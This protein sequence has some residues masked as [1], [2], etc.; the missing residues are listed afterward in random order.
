M[1]NLSPIPSRRLL[2]PLTAPR[3]DDRSGRYQ[4]L[5]AIASP[6]LR[7]REIFV[8]EARLERRRV[9]GNVVVDVGETDADVGADAS[10][11]ASRPYVRQEVLFGGHGQGTE[12]TR[13]RT[14]THV[15]ALSLSLSLS[16]SLPLSLPPSLSLPFSRSLV[17]S[18]AQNVLSRTS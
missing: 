5:R 6:R 9:V 10:S 17:R 18:L 14:R 13:T 4:S 8:R 2:A 3:H 16:P 1:S 7:R 12:R 11:P 15:C